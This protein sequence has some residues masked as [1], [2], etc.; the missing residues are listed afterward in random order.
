MCPA[1]NLV[2]LFE[3]GCLFPPQPFSFLLGKKIKKKKSHLCCCRL[4]SGVGGRAKDVGWRCGVHFWDQLGLFK[5][6]CWCAENFILLGQWQ[7]ALSS[8]CSSWQVPGPSRRRGRVL[9]EQ[10]SPS[11]STCGQIPQPPAPS[12]CFPGL[13]H[14]SSLIYASLAGCRLCCSNMS[15]GRWVWF[16]C[17]GRGLPLPC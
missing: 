14:T 12:V 17:A 8:P 16:G 3:M 11:P 2:C 5:P 15:Q 13:R 6:C 1:V 7:L 4:V 10:G 9:W